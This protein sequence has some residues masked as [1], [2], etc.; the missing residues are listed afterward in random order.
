MGLEH[1]F[2]ATVIFVEERFI[3]HGSVFEGQAVGDYWEP[4]F[5]QVPD[6]CYSLVRKQAAQPWPSRRFR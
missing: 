1:D 5:P 4:G 3:G 6:R 2:Y